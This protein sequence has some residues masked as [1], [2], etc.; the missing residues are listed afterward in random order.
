[1][2]A[3]G[4]SRTGSRD[5]YDIWVI[6]VRIISILITSALVIGWT[7]S[8]FFIFRGFKNKNPSQ[9]EIDFML[10]IGP[11]IGNTFLLMTIPL[12]LSIIAVI[13]RLRVRQNRLG[14]DASFGSEVKTLLIILAFFS[15]SFLARFILDTFFSEEVLGES[16][17][18]HCQDARGYDMYCTPYNLIMWVT[19]T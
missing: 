18:K 2:Q 10:H 9:E 7:L 15:F 13:W 16:M 4:E 1:M 14:L 12:F 3:R 11:L 19:A 8:Y 17:L 6:V 5:V